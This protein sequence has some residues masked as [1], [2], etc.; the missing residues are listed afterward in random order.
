MRALSAVRGVVGSAACSFGIVGKDYM[1]GM[2][3]PIAGMA[4]ITFLDVAAI[5]VGWI[6]Q[7]KTA[8]LF[9]DSGAAGLLAVVWLV[10]SYT[11]GLAITSDE[12]SDGGRSLLEQLPVSL[13][14][15]YWLK[16][17]A[18]ILVVVSFLPL[19]VLFYSVNWLMDSVDRP[20]PL[21]LLGG[22]LELGEGLVGLLAFGLVFAGQAASTLIRKN[23][24]LS[25]LGGVLVMGTVCGIAMGTVEVGPGTRDSSALA[26]ASLLGFAVGGVGLF[27]AR[28]RW[29]VPVNDRQGAL[30]AI[31]VR[32]EVTTERV[33]SPWHRQFLIP[34]WLGLLLP[35]LVWLAGL[36]QPVAG[37]DANLLSPA[38]LALAAI[39]GA[40]HAALCVFPPEH[41]G[42][43]F[44]LH[45]QPVPWGRY[46]M[47]RVGMHAGFAALWGALA[48]LPYGLLGGQW[49]VVG[50]MA[51]GAATAGLWG[52]ALAVCFESRI[53]LGLTSGF[54]AVVVAFFLS[55][56]ARFADAPVELAW[57]VFW[58]GVIP[59]C[60]ALV[61]N[62]P[63]RIREAVSGRR[64]TVGA[65]VL[66][67]STLCLPLMLMTSPI[68]LWT[69]LFP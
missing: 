19:S 56:C 50:A 43:R 31:G 11:A 21:A 62:G 17:L 44:F 12:D 29:L 20:Q 42:T 68:D 61:L 25:A 66:V 51:Y 48:G 54:I 69:I 4:T 55:L 28:G 46:L 24:I 18:G 37:Q 7:I 14:R 60:I 26:V 1:R 39:A 59:L 2:Q 65:L 40:V 49:W 6:F 9:H 47:E 45:Y 32:V 10:V 57:L 36:H 33:V 38:A 64:Q 52:M 23:P 13:N 5:L 41:E 34:T 22:L 3:I 63:A 8:R 15:L 53:V 27:A 58:S 67:Q 30:E 16:T 35:P